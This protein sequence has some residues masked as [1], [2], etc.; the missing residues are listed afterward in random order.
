[1]II[2]KSDILRFKDLAADIR[3]QKNL[4]VDS[5]IRFGGGKILKNAYECMIQYDCSDSNEELLIS[6]E[7][8]YPLATTSSAEFITIKKEG[9]GL[10]LMDGK[11]VVKVPTIETKNF[12]AIPK[13]IP[14][15]DVLDAE[16]IKSLKRAWPLC[17]PDEEKAAKPMY[18]YTLIGNNAICSGDGICGLR[19]PI[20]Q[21]ITLALRGD[22]ARSISNHKWTGFS[23]SD[24]N[25]FFHMDG[26]VVGFS[27]TSVPYVDIRYVFD[28]DTEFAFSYAA[29]DL[30]SFNKLFMKYSKFPYCSFKKG[31]LDAW[32]MYS[33]ETL[34]RPAEQINVSDEFG[35]SPI[36]MN[37]ILS[38]LDCE[39]I[40]L[41]KGKSFYY[42]KSKDSTASTFI[43]QMSKE[44]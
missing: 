41:Y 3:R 27:K 23:Q 2:K 42:V 37:K 36:A 24:T 32:D 12:L 7:Y 17:S 26:V 44:K 1:M 33:E 29:S 34:T 4:M 30:E 9:K 31:C 6:E 20:S 10:K 5:Y 18:A 25:V 21:N 8:I 15:T 22:I 39:D 14:Q 13:I 16:F 11:E 38:A 40:D 35:F 28:F 19:I 43:M